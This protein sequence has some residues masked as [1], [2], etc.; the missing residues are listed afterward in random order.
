M[1]EDEIVGLHYQFNGHELEQGPGDGEQQESLACCSP[2]G[3]KESDTVE[4]QNNKKYLTHQQIS[5]LNF[6]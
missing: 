1:T 5:G 3:C 4:K 2:L 6:Y